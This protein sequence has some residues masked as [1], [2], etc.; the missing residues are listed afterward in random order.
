MH[1]QSQNWSEVQYPINMFNFKLLL[2]WQY[3]FFVQTIYSKFNS[4]YKYG[5]YVCL[6]NVCDKRE[7]W[8]IIQYNTWYTV[9][10]YTLKI[11]I[12]H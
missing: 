4:P 3:S 11:K 8:V 2:N 6:T 7:K 1:K 10:D 12:K 5:E 9:I